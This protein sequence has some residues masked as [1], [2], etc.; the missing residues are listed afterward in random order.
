MSLRYYQND[1]TWGGRTDLSCDWHHCWAEHPGL[2]EMERAVWALMC[3][4]H[5][6][7]LCSWVV[8]SSSCHNVLSS[9]TVSWINSFAFKLVLCKYFI[10]AA[11]RSYGGTLPFISDWSSWVGPPSCPPSPI[12]T[13]AP[14]SIVPHYLTPTEFLLFLRFLRFLPPPLLPTILLCL[15]GKHKTALTCYFS[16]I[17]SSPADT[18]NP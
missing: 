3:L 6:T 7:A 13:K 12:S 5:S 11:G 15:I 14:L 2:S 8:L 1:M 17:S 18:L 4:H 16:V 10:P 9:G